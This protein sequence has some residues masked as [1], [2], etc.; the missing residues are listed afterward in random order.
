MSGMLYSIPVI[1]TGYR[2]VQIEDEATP[3]AQA[4]KSG[5]YG[6]TVAGMLGIGVLLL[7]V[8]Y[9][10]LCRKYQKRIIELQENAHPGWNWWKLRKQVTEL[11]VYPAGSTKLYDCL[12]LI[13][14][15][16]G[17]SPDFLHQIYKSEVFRC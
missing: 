7:L 10:I 1:L 6:D 2:I 15:I 5:Y 8:I 12:N 9:F 16:R 17:S 4:A 14:K 13:R 3:L 11:E